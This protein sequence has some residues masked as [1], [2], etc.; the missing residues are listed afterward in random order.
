MQSSL[1]DRVEEAMR[2]DD[3][4]RDKQSDL[5]VDIYRE[6]S[7]DAKNK[8]DL[9]FICLCGWSLLTLLDGQ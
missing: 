7:P 4:D 3:E 8:I 1:I 2:D 6:A 5:L 9:I